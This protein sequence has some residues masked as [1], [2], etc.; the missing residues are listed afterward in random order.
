MKID[1]LPEGKR[2]KIEGFDIFRGIAA[3]LVFLFHFWVLF[4]EQQLFSGDFFFGSF[5]EAGHIGVDIFFVIS[6]F[7]VFLSLVYSTSIKEYLKRRFWR[8]VP[9]ALFFIAVL[10]IIR[11]EFDLLSWINLGAHIFFTQALFAETYHGFP[12]MWTLSVEAL[13]YLSLIPLVYCTRKK[14]THLIFGLIFLTILSFLFRYYIAQQDI[15]FALSHNSHFETLQI[16]R[17]FYTEQ[18]WGKFDQFAL[19]IFLGIIWI[20]REKFQKFF[21]PSRSLSIFILGFLGLWFWIDI[22]ANLGGGFREIL[23]YQVFLHGLI[24]LCTFFLFLGFLFLS[25]KARKFFTPPWL[26]F[27]GEISYGVYLWHMPVI[28]QIDKWGFEGWNAFFPSVFFILLFASC[29][30]FFIEK[31]FIKN[32]ENTFKF[33]KK[34]GILYIDQMK[35]TFHSLVHGK[36]Y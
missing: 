26:L 9:F 1:W 17:I 16:Q 5:F 32:R 3:L 31:P 34:K 29:T 2:E 27:L 35:K 4:F 22:F 8:I 28:S 12:A 33:Y 36:N 14:L 7:L 6:G 20:F 25:S 15:F 11:Q 24:G 19:G 13:F 10:F 30:Y 18:L 21:T 23:F